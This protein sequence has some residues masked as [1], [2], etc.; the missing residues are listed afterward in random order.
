MRPRLIR[1]LQFGFGISLLFLVCIAVASFISIQNLLS[2]AKLVDHSKLVVSQLESGLSIMKDAETGQR[3]YL[4]TNDERFLEPYNGSYEKASH[5][6]DEF[7]RLTT[8]NPEQRANA[9]ILED[10]VTKKLSILQLLIDKH[11]S[12]QQV[13]AADLIAGKNAMDELRLAVTK[14]EQGEDILLQQRLAR[15][16]RFTTLTPIFLVLATLASIIISVLAYY[17][18]IN[19]IN[20]RAKLYAELEVKEQETAQ[21]NEELN[22]SNEELAAANEEINAANEDLASFN[23]ELNASNEEL[24]SANEEL[25]AANEQLVEAQDNVVGL[26]EQLGAANEELSATVEELTT[27]RESLQKLNEE[28][29]DRVE[30]RTRK[31]T[32]SEGRFRV[33]METM[34]QIAWTNWPDG[35][36]AFFN[37]H[38]YDYTGLSEAQSLGWKW[39]SSV[40]PDDLP[41]ASERYNTII[42]K[43][44]PGEFEARKK[45]TDGEYRW[46]LVRM[47]PVR[48]NEGQIQL[49][50][51]TATDIDDLKNLQQ[52]KDDFI[53]IASH[54]LKTPVTSLKMS[55]QLLDRTKDNPASPVAGKLIGQANKS[56]ERVSVL[57][58]ELL[59]VSKLNQGQLHLNKKNFDIDQLISDSSQ[60]VLL[61]GS[62]EI[63]TGG[64]TG[65]QVFGDPERIEQVLVNFINNAVKYAPDSREIRVN[66]QK[67]KG[68]VKFSVSDNG[69][70]IPP[71]K[72]QYLFERYYRVDSQGIQFSGLGLGL[73]ISAEIVKR[74]GGQIG[75]NTELGKGSTFWFTLPTED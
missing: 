12:G 60:H 42:Q 68:V 20:E 71:E 37:K 52:Q 48:N 57:I 15:L 16:Q 27:S 24:A 7:K 31:L 56:L 69:P 4:Y 19:G 75:V 8:D 72:V 6:F 49:W 9:Q 3:G 22:A 41:H 35:E 21:L 23:E 65:V 63:V 2:S 62:H 13:T 47:Q 36:I 44:E 53:S 64:N 46:H 43:G 30:E 38:W 11:K 28:L 66:T 39:T 14:T 59:N 26:N 70:G 50:V 25:N 58:E 5:A 67:E 29:E 34:P 32:E 18:V 51:G 73:Y 54:E 45:R 40:H 33:I 17:R 1:N 10:I 61:N 55:L 74:H